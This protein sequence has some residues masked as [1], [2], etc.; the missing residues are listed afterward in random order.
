[1]PTGFARTRSRV[2]P[3]L[4]GSN[5]ILG[6]FY[7]AIML[8]GQPT[9]QYSST[10]ENTLVFNYKTGARFTT[11]QVTMDSI[12]AGP[13]YR[14]GS[15]FS[16][17][18]YE[19]CTPYSGVH[20][21]GV[22]FRAD[23]LQK[24]AGG[25]HPPMGAG[26]FCPPGVL[27]RFAFANQNDTF[28]LRLVDNTNH[29][30]MN[31]LGERAWKSTKPK[32]EKASGLVFTSELRD[33]PR[34]LKQMSKSFHNI[35]KALGGSASSRANREAAFGLMQP[36]TVADEFLAAEF[37]WIPF[38]KDLYR[39]N[40]VI[41]QYYDIVLKLQK[42]NNT[43]V[44]RR[45]PLEGK[46]V[47]TVINS[48]LANKCC[49]VLMNANYFVA[50]PS[51]NVLELD[52]TSIS[53]VGKFRFYRPEFDVK[54]GDKITQW[55]QAMQFLTISGFRVTP[56]NVYAAIPWTWLIDWFTNVGDYLDH[57]NDVWIDS[58]VNEYCFVMQHR[59]TIREFH[60]ELPFHSGTVSLNFRRSIDSKQ[61]AQGSSPYGFG[62]SWDDLDPQQWA[63]LV[64]L[65]LSRNKIAR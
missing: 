26:D 4:T 11:A 65:G 37:G 12:H 21:N 31:G 25:F 7:P 62:L 40:D 29:P 53:A 36:K 28:M 61:R 1:M 42:R 19:W 50:P 3:N 33:M 55:N 49:P 8:G 2:T 39:F 13:P 32:L 15:P 41:N 58:V 57:L 24:Y 51:F 22:Y 45:V 44:R 43:W 60:Q 18:K 16:S 30:S 63:I 54:S 34:M 14:S 27:D 5:V 64:A 35:W 9:G 10:P 6:K 38:V 56:S 52:E 48:G 59:E 20:G 23:K 47:S 17:L 46:T